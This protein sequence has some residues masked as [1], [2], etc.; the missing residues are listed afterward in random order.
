MPRKGPVHAIPVRTS[1]VRRLVLGLIVLVILGAVVWFATGRS[2]NSAAEPT[3]TGSTKMASDT[4][5]EQSGSTRTTGGATCSVEFVSEG[6]PLDP[7]PVTEGSLFPDLPIPQYEGSVFAGWY[8]SDEAARSLDVTERV[9]MARMVDCSEP[10]LL[11]SGWVT[12]G[13]NAAEGTQLPILMYHRVATEPGQ[14]ENSS[15]PN[16]YVERED[17]EGHLRYIK[18][19]NFYLPSW[20]EISA[21][22]DGDLYLPS[23][24]VVVTSDDGHESWWN[25]AG[26]LLEE[27][28]IMSTVFLITSRSVGPEGYPYVLRRSHTSSMHELDGGTEGRMVRWSEEEVKADLETSASELGGVREVVAYPFGQVNETSRRAVTAAG[29][30]LGR[31]AGEGY[32]TVGT[33]KL[34]LPIILVGHGVTVEDLAERIG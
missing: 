1:Q 7:M 32:V 26:P 23:R 5:V 31:L 27:H 25:E 21:F 8:T 19:N 33:D 20:M 4:A 14:A 24:S 3:G 12:P 6:E 15:R 13:E 30:E 9:N 16:M 2:S 22:I 10:L 34:G 29:Y 28:E 11:T 18:D 17:L